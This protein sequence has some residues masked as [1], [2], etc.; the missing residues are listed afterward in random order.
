MYPGESITSAALFSQPKK[1][2]KL[3]ECGFIVMPLTANCTYPSSAFRRS[4]YQIF[5]AWGF[6]VFGVIVA[7]ESCPNLI[8]FTVI[9]H[10]NEIEPQVAP[11]KVCSCHRH[12]SIS[13]AEF[14]FGSE[15]I[16]HP[17]WWLPAHLLY[18]RAPMPPVAPDRLPAQ[19]SVPL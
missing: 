17:F 14:P 8:S 13:V 5:L 19:P 16:G 1:C 18:M 15:M 3:C 7:T 2:Q 6:Y 10:G 4:R 12:G 11:E 9:H